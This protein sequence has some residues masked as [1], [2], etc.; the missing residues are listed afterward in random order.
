[1]IATSSDRKNAESGATKKPRNGTI[2]ESGMSY[3]VIF[4]YFTTPA[5]SLSLNTIR[6]V[7]FLGADD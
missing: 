3:C 5:V 6:S 1:M 4:V 7:F 2:I